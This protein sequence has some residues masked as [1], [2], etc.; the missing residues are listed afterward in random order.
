MYHQTVD[1]IQERIG[2]K[3]LVQIVEDILDKCLADDI[4]R[5]NGIGTDNM[6]CIIVRFQHKNN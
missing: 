3:K 4:R 6:T 5:T 2:K 1:F